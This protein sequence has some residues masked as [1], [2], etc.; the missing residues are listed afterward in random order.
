MT[1]ETESTPRSSVTASANK[2]SYYAKW[3]LSISLR[4]SFALAQLT[5]SAAGGLPSRTFQEYGQR[6]VRGAFIPNPR[7]AA[8]LSDRTGDPTQATP[9]ET[10]VFCWIRSIPY[11]IT[12]VT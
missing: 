3:C 6:V 2:P 8:H 11:L 1:A 4:V 9:S 12:A 5:L 10:S 7:G